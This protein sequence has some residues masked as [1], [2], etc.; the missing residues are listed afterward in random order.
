MTSAG[1][2][3]TTTPAPARADLP[4]L[5]TLAAAFALRVFRLDYNGPFID[6]SFHSVAVAYGNARFLTGDVHLYPQLSSWVHEFAGLHGARVLS[7]V[8][9]TATV[10]CVYGLARVVAARLVPAEA[11]RVVALG[12]AVGSWVVVSGRAGEWVLHL[13]DGELLESGV[14]IVVWRRPLDRVV[15][16]TAAMQRVSFET[17]ALSAESLPILSFKSLIR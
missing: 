10:A 11:V 3:A 12:A 13:R 9:G 5:A 7:A 16:F 1:G 4:L 2:E 15:R 17:E 8:F 6:E 14:G